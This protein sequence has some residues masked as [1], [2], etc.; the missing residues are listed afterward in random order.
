VLNGSTV[1][2]FNPAGA[3][4]TGLNPA[5]CYFIRR[6][7]ANNV[8]LAATEG[9]SAIALTGLGGAQQMTLTPNGTVPAGLTVCTCYFVT[10]VS[11][12][13]YSLATTRSNAMSCTQINICALVGAGTMT[14]T[15]NGCLPCGLSTSTNYFVIKTDCNTYA[16]AT[17]R[18]LAVQGSPCA[19]T[20]SCLNAPATQT[21]TPC[22]AAP[23]GLTHC[24]CYYVTF[25]DPSTPCTNNFQLATTEANAL[26][27]TQIDI[28]ALNA[29]A[30]LVFNPAGAVPTGL[31]ATCTYYVIKVDACTIQLATSAVNA[32]TGCQINL[33]AINGGATMTL[34]P[35]TSE[36]GS[37]AFTGSNDG[38]TFGAIPSGPATI[39][40]TCTTAQTIRVESCV[41][42]NFLRTTTITTEGQIC[43]NIVISGCTSHSRHSGN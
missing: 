2:T 23:A 41:N 29:A 27:G 37:I 25:A 30:T 34:T 43:V 31:V 17:T 36:A 8:Q 6:T 20:L 5:C 35:C 26:L 9:G 33:S 28:T 19:V 38:V 39:C 16:V 32:D 15:P 18:A 24:T 42:Y 4:P 10:D 1:M 13:T 22:G 12:N 21:F 3:V 11:C 14:I 40:Y 7:D